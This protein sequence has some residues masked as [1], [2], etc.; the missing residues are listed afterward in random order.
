[1]IFGVLFAWL[2]VARS[3]P[4]NTMK[5]LRGVDEKLIHLDAKIEVE[6]ARA[7]ERWTAMN[8][9]VGR[10]ERLIDA[11]TISGAANGAEHDDS[12]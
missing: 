10:I 7:A 8:E 11:R 3:S 9:R 1:V 6:S 5:Q 2:K 4:E 12:A